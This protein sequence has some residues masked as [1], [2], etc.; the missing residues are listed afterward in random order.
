MLLYHIVYAIDHRPCTVY[1]VFGRLKF[2]VSADDSEFGSGAR[3]CHSQA[4]GGELLNRTKPL[5]FR[6]IDIICI[7]A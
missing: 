5:D 7:R 2:Q 1:A 3:P 6:Y 4:L